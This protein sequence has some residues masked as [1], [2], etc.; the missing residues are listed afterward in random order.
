MRMKLA[1]VMSQTRVLSQIIDLS[2]ESNKIWKI[3]PNSCERAFNILEEKA[4]GIRVQ[5]S[6]IWT[7][8]AAYRI[9]IPFSAEEVAFLM[10][11]TILG[12]ELIKVCQS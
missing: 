10:R 11:W 1:E 3:V 7:L 9:S 2:M 5:N 4:S 8:K 6:I 12:V